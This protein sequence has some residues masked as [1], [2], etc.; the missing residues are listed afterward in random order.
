MKVATAATLLLSMLI[1][2]LA[3]EEEEYGLLNFREARGMGGG[4]VKFMMVSREF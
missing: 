3:A 2:T 4:L 1:V